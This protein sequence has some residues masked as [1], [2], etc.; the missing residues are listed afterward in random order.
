MRVFS[1][2]VFRG[3]VL[4]GIASIVGL[5]LGRSL[6]NMP[7]STLPMENQVPPDTSQKFL[8]NL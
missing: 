2:D 5:V 7:A 8:R 4:R 1:N 3:F 6:L